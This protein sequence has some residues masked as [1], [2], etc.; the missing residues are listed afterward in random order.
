LRSEFLEVRLL[1]P[2]KGDPPL[3]LTRTAPLANAVAVFA[4]RRGSTLSR[5]YSCLLW[6]VFALSTPA[7]AQDRMPE[8]PTDQLTEVQKKAVNEFVA[9]RGYAPVGPFVPLLRSPELM[10]RVKA[11]GDYLQG[12]GLGPKSVLPPKLRE[13]VIL[14]TARQ[15]TAQFEWVSHY[16]H[17][18]EAGLSPEIIQALA[19][20]RRPARMS[21][22]EEIVYDFCDELHRNK[23]VSDTTYSRALA[24]FHEQGIIDMVS[25]NGYY[26]FLSMV[27]NVARRPPP[28][29]TTSA[30]PVLPR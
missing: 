21:D 27:V 11:M 15:W 16:P 8:I 1:T 26:T 24:K 18:I 30:L 22:D 17:A 5:I 6:V 2:A 4:N 12:H 29:G 7:F 23:S 13:L 19:E 14:I 10:L 3:R 28:K 25:V 20:G 9:G